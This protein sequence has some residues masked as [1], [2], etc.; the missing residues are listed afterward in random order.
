MIQQGILTNYSTR[1]G[2][3]GGGLL[4]NPLKKFQGRLTP[5]EPQSQLFF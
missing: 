2:G 3:G 5:H 4:T 1:G